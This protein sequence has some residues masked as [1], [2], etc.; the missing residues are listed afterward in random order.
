MWFHNKISENVQ[1]CLLLY[2][3]TVH[4]SWGHFC[5]HLSLNVI[6][7]VPR[8]LYRKISACKELFTAESVVFTTENVAPS[9]PCLV[10]RRLWG[11]N[12]QRVKSTGESQDP[13]TWPI[14][15]M[16]CH[17]SFFLRALPSIRFPGIPSY[18]S[19]HSLVSFA[20]P[21]SSQ[22]LVSVL[23]PLYVL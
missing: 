8:V 16:W 22:P 10:R 12:L 18:F 4:V 15:N 17:H 2:H 6:T 1:S 21:S 11:W 3:K 9:T 20:G 23:C 13:L 19:G 5:L 14:D 7:V